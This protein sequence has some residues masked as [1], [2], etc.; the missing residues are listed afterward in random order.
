MLLN[1]KT[2]ISASDDDWQ[3]FDPISISD[4]LRLVSII[5]ASG[6]PIFSLY[7]YP[8]PILV[9]IENSSPDFPIT[10][11]SLRKVEW[12]EDSV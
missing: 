8:G 4:F 10:Q 3:A 5:G 6:I 12:F 2:E 1:V 11:H 7:L 9:V